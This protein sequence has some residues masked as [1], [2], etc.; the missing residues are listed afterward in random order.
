MRYW[1]TE[2]NVTRSGKTSGPARR[3]PAAMP[4]QGREAAARRGG[5]S[6]SGGGSRPSVVSGGGGSRP[7]VVSAGSVKNYPF[8]RQFYRHQTS[9]SDRL[10]RFLYFL[11][12]AALIYVFIIGESGAIRITQLRLQRARLEENIAN[13]KRSSAQLEKT[14]ERLETNDFYIEK[15]GRERYG[16]VRPGDRVYRFIPIDDRDF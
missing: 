12:L 5:S 10:R 6:G 1:G 15:I 13:L 14:I 8:L 9:I 7:S 2:D 3:R 4:S 11:L 16:Y